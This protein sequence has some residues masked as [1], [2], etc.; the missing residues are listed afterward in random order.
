MEYQEMRRHW[1]SNALFIHLGTDMYHIHM[2]DLLYSK[3]TYICKIAWY[4]YL[5]IVRWNIST[6]DARIAIFLGYFHSDHHI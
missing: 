4:F 1:M 6:Y 2:Y 5:A 3:Y